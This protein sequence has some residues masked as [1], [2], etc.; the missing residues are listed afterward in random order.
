ME[1]KPWLF[2]CAVASTVISA[3]LVLVT[4]A[5]TCRSQRTLRSDAEA[6]RAD[7][8]ALRLQLAVLSK[9]VA[10]EAEARK[11]VMRT[12]YKSMA[13]F[14]R[15]ARDFVVGEAPNPTEIESGVPE[16]AHEGPHFHVLRIQWRGDAGDTYAVRGESATEWVADAET[17]EAT[18][19]QFEA[20]LP[21]IQGDEYRLTVHLLTRGASLLAR[22]SKTKH[23]QPDRANFAGMCEKGDCYH[24]TN[25]AIPRFVAPVRSTGYTAKV[26]TDPVRQ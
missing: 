13:G 18:P 19:G 14:R 25:F 17:R 15:H 10:E 2:N 26:K 1:V 24:E 4:L 20:Y 12:V 3:L 8:E 16:K 22:G 21:C 9:D 5:A 7:A 23:V 11:G 6:L